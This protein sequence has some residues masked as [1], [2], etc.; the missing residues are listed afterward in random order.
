MITIPKMEKL[1]NNCHE[2]HR[3]RPTVEMLFCMLR[4][5]HSDTNRVV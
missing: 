1:P 2:M 3:M 4:S 5:K